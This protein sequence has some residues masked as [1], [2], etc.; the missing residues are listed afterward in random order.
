VLFSVAMVWIFYLALEPYVRRVWPETLTSWIR[1]FEGNWRDPLLG[2]DVLAGTALGVM[3]TL[4]SIVDYQIPQWIGENLIPVPL[5]SITAANLM[6]QSTQNFGA[7][8]STVILALYSGLTL[9]LALV[10]IRMVAKRAWLTNVIS[11]ILFAVA[12]ARYAEGVLWQLANVESLLIQCC[13]ALVLLIVLN[14]H[15]LVALIFCLLARALLL[16]FPVTWDFAAWY[17]TAALSGIVP[18]V[19]ILLGSFY[20]AL[21]RRSL[22]EAAQK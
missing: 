14:R 10:L 1:L 3:S 2:G 17:R 11:V 4:L 22:L 7:L 18:I 12:T 20:L 19:V 15:G 8:A 5:P 21:D 13:V 6:L 16:D 9:L